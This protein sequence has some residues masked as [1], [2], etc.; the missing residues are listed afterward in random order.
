MADA[1]GD[2]MAAGDEADG[3]SRSTLCPRCGA[4]IEPPTP[5]AHGS[6]RGACPQCDLSFSVAT[7]SVPADERSTTGSTSGG[8]VST[9]R[10]HRTDGVRALRERAFPIYGLEAAWPGRR[11]IGGCRS[12]NGR[13]NG[14]D[15]GYGEAHDPDGP[16]LLVETLAPL[17]K[18]EIV[19]RLTAQDLAQR[20]WQSGA[21]HAEVRPSFVS[22]DP[23]A[24]WGELMLD[25]D[26]EPVRFSLLTAGAHWVA[27]ARVG[28][29]VV[30]LDGRH[31]A[32]EDV[33]LV[34]VDD[35]G[36]YLPAD[37]K[38]AFRDVV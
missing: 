7:L 11:W 29:E 27:L 16:L 25:I 5:P 38:D 33:R 19:H 35:V 9:Q 13:V 32:T 21:D 8:E 31:F 17:S 1:F 12:S 23:V 6:A 36:P 10:S 14:I 20:I 26:A 24:S 18:L 2:S 3:R 22:T 34:S 28:E 15:L 4:V 30:A 37:D